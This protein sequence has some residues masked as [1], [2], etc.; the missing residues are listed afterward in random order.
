MAKSRDSSSETTEAANLGKRTSQDG[1]VKVEKF[2]ISI[3]Q[4]NADSLARVSK[5]SGKPGRNFIRADVDQDAAEDNHLDEGQKERG[6]NLLDGSKKM[7][8][9]LR[10]LPTSKAARKEKKQFHTIADL[11][12][13]Q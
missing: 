6:D 2:S 3:D 5:K 12:D 7:K 9:S 1:E 10:L 11:S 8:V 4:L 13:I